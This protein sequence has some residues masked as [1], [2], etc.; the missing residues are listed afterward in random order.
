MRRANEI[1]FCRMCVNAKAA[2]QLVEEKHF[3]EVEPLLAEFAQL[4]RLEQ[5]AN[6][7][8]LDAQADGGGGGKGGKGPA[9]AR[10]REHK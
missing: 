7:A 6:E 3:R 5:E 2:A 8:F 9:A 1:W 10:A 4:V